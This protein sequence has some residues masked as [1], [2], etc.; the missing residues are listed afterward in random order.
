M[1]ALLVLLG[2]LLGAPVA[3]I[4]GITTLQWVVIGLNAASYGPDIARAVETAHK[5]L[6]SP[7]FEVW[8]KVNAA[9]NGE[10]TIRVYPGN[11]NF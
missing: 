5:L 2:L 3:S 4:A 8:V 6:S 11:N 9:R 7:E 10:Y 1:A